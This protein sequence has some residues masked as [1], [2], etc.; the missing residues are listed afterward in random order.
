MSNKPRQDTVRPDSVFF[1]FESLS[2]GLS[3]RK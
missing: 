2:G 1:P 3:T